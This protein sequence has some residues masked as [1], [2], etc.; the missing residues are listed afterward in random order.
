[1]AIG[2]DIKATAKNIEGKVQEATGNITGNKKDQLAGKAKQAQASVE[3]AVEDLKDA[4]HDA[5]N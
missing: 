4:V 1:M 2:K 5:T 3:H